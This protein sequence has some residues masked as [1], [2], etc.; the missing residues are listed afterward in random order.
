MKEIIKRVLILS[1]G[2][3]FIILGIIGL[4]LPVLQGI[5]F[6]FIGLIILSRASKTVR[7]WLEKLKTRYPKF[8]YY[9]DKAK[10]K[11]RGWKKKVM[12]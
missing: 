11:V 4:F 12:G 10:E 3:F 7:N 2:W 9:L 8:G 6:L 5:L 1:L